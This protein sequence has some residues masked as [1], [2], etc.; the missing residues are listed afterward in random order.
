MPKPHLQ[1]PSQLVQRFNSAAAPV[2]LEGAVLR[3]NFFDAVA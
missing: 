1:A 2:G 3:H